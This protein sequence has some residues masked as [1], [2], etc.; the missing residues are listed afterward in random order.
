TPPIHT[1]STTEAGSTWIHVMQDCGRGVNQ[2]APNLIKNSMNSV[3]CDERSLLVSTKLVSTKNHR[4]L[5]LER[6]ISLSCFPAHPVSPRPGHPN[7]RRQHPS[8]QSRIMIF[9]HDP[10]I[11]NVLPLSFASPRELKSERGSG[12][13]LLS[14]CTKRNQFNWSSVLC[15]TRIMREIPFRFVRA[16]NTE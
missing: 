14:D 5:E 2:D 9:V 7:S 1:D 6:M 8:R 15:E 11:P 13:A 10:G 16:W 12:D 3:E 4:V